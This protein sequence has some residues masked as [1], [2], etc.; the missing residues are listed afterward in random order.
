MLCSYPGKICLRSYG[1]RKELLAKEKVGSFKSVREHLQM[2]LKH[3]HAHRG[4]FLKS[5]WNICSNSNLTWVEQSTLIYALKLNGSFLTLNL[6]TCPITRGRNEENRMKKLTTYIYLNC[7]TPAHITKV[8]NIT[9]LLYCFQIIF[10][11][12][13]QHRGWYRSGLII[14]LQRYVQNPRCTSI[15]LDLMIIDEL[16]ISNIRTCFCTRFMRIL[17]NVYLLL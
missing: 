5:H 4:R 16:L 6:K 10:W 15:S 1:L 9:W 3:V 17:S 11:P 8:H 14:C 7:S 13:S 2:R 12:C